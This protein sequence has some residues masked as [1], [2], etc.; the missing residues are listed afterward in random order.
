MGG[1]WCR[2][3]RDA[4]V[5]AAGASGGPPRAGRHGHVHRVDVLDAGRHVGHRS[6]RRHR[7]ERPLRLTT[8][9]RVRQPRP[10]LRYIGLLDPQNHASCGGDRPRGI[11]L[12]I[13]LDRCYGSRAT[14]RGR[15]ESLSCSSRSRWSRR[16]GFRSSGRGERPTCSR[17]WRASSIGSA[18]G[19]GTNARFSSPRGAVDSGKILSPID[20]PHDSRSPGGVVSTIRRCCGQ[21]GSTDGT[22]SGAV[23]VSGQ[24]AIGAGDML[25]VTDNHGVRAITPAALVTTIA[26]E[27]R[28][29]AQR[30]SAA[31][32]SGIRGHRRR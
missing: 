31:R 28:C 29:W 8:R 1:G 24:V 22:G 23:L 3:R 12:P 20:Q 9:A 2:R 4:G 21:T 30:T 6:G 17:R 11:A 32:T 15:S 14:S 18:D 26:G 5:V 19:T 7:P 13:G 16:R 25:Y 10:H 27:V